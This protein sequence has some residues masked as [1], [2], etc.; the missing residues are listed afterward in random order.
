MSGSSISRPD[1]ARELGRLLTGS[2]AR[3]VA[4]RLA[5]GDTLTVALQ[6]V[7][8]ALRP[9]LRTLLETEGARSTTTTIAPLWTMPGHLAR[10]G[11]LTSSVDR[12]VDGARRSVTCSTYNFQRSSVLW[13]AL[14]RAAR[15]PD[16]TLRVYVD[17][18]AADGG[19]SSSTPSTV[20]VAAHL[21]PGVVLRTRPF[22]GA[23]VRNH[24]KFLAIDHRFL[25]VTSANFSWSAEHG[26]VE[27]GVLADNVNLV[28]AVE[29]QLRRV[30]ESLYE[31]VERD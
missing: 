19:R 30:E 24:A 23:A 7:A 3:D 27:L 15:R 26:N 14:R 9:R 25:L 4:D 2:E 29:S 21:H 17:A 8:P 10:S 28:Q 1:A 5:D 16:V 31:L 13:S 20:E 22:D 12:L 18:Q 11:P 6:A